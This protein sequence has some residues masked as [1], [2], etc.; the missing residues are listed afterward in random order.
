M[1]RKRGAVGSGGRRNQ[2]AG[3]LSSS[4]VEVRII[5][6]EDGN[7]DIGLTKRCNCSDRRKCDD[8]APRKEVCKEVRSL[9]LK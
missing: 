8:L 7:A 2:D 3:R 6:R 5:R 9:G 4:C 1:M